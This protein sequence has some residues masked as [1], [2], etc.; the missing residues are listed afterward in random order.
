MKYSVSVPSS[1]LL[2]TNVKRQ[3]GRRKVVS[4]SLSDFFRRCEIDWNNGFFVSVSFSYRQEIYSS[5]MKAMEKGITSRTVIVSHAVGSWYATTFS[6]VQLLSLAIGWS[7]H[8][9][10][11]LAHIR[12][13]CFWWSS[14]AFINCSQYDVLQGRKRA[15]H[16]ENEGEFKAI[17]SWRQI[18]RQRPQQSLSF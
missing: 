8:T 1:T 7:L 9:K 13:E 6:G 5:P 12:A 2:P 4:A 14:T 3:K 11:L 16:D 17:L 18:Q 10:R 15:R